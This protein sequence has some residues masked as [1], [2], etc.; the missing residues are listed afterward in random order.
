[1]RK[2]RLCFLKI[3][4][5]LKSVD[6]HP[7]KQVKNYTKIKENKVENTSS[8][9]KTTNKHYQNKDKVN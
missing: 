1:M 7:H 8:A 2:M 6:E 3:L 9:G 4:D 5:I